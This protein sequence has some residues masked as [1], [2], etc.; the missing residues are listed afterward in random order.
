MAVAEERSYTRAADRL[1]VVQQ[2]VSAAVKQLEAELGVQL[3]V[4]TS[5]K[6]EL[7]AAGEAL[8][9]QGRYALGAV[10]RAWEAAQEAGRVSPSELR[11]A[12][13]RALGRA[14]LSQLHEAVRHRLSSARLYWRPRYNDELVPDVH[15]GTIDVGLAVFPDRLGSLSY[16]RI[17]ELRLAVVVGSRNPLADAATLT[18]ADLRDEQILVP[19]RALGPR[20][21]EEFE[22]LFRDAGLQ[23]HLLE[24][25]DPEGGQAPP[26]ARGRIV[27]LGP[28]HWAREFTDRNGD[29]TR[30]IPL[31]DD[32]PAVPLELVW[33]RGNDSALL[34]EFIEICRDAGA[35]MSSHPDAP[36]EAAD[37]EPTRVDLDAYWSA[38]AS[39]V[40]G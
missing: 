40:F 1:H 5:R 9:E 11:I 37:E 22:Q 17:G 10:Q 28:L 23:C 38:S 6:V 18:L 21:Y 24:T 12:Y 19:P 36:A 13:N 4:R 39:F 31:D 14:P 35:A 8:L 2:S 16:L 32:S 29:R 3:L 30:C 26:G 20:Y 7:T 27:G 33:R 34:Q 25:P 15:A